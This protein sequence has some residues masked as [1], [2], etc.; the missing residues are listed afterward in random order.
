MDRDKLFP[1]ILIF[2]LFLPLLL[3]DIAADTGGPESAPPSWPEFMGP[4][5]HGVAADVAGS[6][7][8][9]PKSDFSL[10]TQWISKLGSG[11]SGISRQAGGAIHWHAD[12]PYWA[13]EPPWPTGRLTGQTIWMLDDFTEENGATGIVPGSHRRLQGPETRWSRRRWW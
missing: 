2:H 11:Y 1:T 9:F 12:C 13:L 7:P 5:R 4:G 3:T 8:I 6:L 10:R